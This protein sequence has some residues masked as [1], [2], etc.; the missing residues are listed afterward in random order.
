[1]VFC[2]TQTLTNQYQ[3]L[4]TGIEQYQS[5]VTGIELF[6]FETWI[7]VGNIAIIFIFVDLV[8]VSN[9]NT[10]TAI[11]CCYCKIPITRD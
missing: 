5:L 10:N 9:I 1:M 6:V 11:R 4:V 2:H 8:D 3:S 7:R